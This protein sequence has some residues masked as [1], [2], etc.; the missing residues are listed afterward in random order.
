METYILAD[1]AIFDDC[2]TELR[3]H[4]EVHSCASG[5]RIK[6]KSGYLFLF[7]GKWLSDAL[8]KWITLVWSYLHWLI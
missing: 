6:S 8:V 1:R 5:S 3:Q 7:I 2:R 4:I